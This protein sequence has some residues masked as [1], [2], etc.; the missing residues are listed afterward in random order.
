MRKHYKS[1][2]SAAIVS[3]LN[4][5]VATNTCFSDTPDLDVGLVG[6]GVTKMVQLFCGW[7]SLITAVYPMRREGNIFGTLED[8]VRQFGAPLSLLSDNAKSQIGKAV[9]E[10]IRMY[11]IKD[12]QCEPHHQNQHFAERRIQELSNTLLDCTGAKPSLWL[13]CVQYVVYLLN[14]L[15]TES[16]HWKTPIEAVTGQRPY[17][18]ALMA[19]HW[20]VPVYFKHNK[21]QR[22]PLFPI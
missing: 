5:V 12:F 11:A 9:R 6:H 19:F 18:S 2:L 16:R 22:Q 14:R 10:I 20:Y 4:E 1:L 3:R 17:I 7:Q 15:S 13:L 21:Y 8:F